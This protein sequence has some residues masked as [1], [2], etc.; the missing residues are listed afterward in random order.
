MSGPKEDLGL[1]ELL[2]QRG[3]G[4]HQLQGRNLVAHPWI[5][6]TPALE[7]VREE[8]EPPALL[9]NPQHTRVHCWALFAE[10]LA[11][12]CLRLLITHTMV[13]QPALAHLWHLMSLN[14][15]RWIVVSCYS[16]KAGSIMLS[17]LKEGGSPVKSISS[18]LLNV[19][20][21]FHCLRDIF[22]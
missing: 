8:W 14:I 2:M 22:L 6:C 12:S 19:D 5:C 17:W 3:Q 9:C 10:S 1:L 13:L 21:P 15:D 7:V 16:V 20:A 18:W 4:H 11:F